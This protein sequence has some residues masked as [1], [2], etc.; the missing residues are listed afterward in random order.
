MPRLLRMPEVAANAVEAVLQEWKVEENT[1]FSAADV[2]ATV[3]TEKAVVDVEAD[4]EGVL[5]KTLVP[6]GAQVEIGAPIALI[7]DAAE[8]VDDL[9]TVMERLGVTANGAVVTPQR[10]EVPDLSG[11]EDG[12]PQ[13]VE[14]PA[15]VQPE[16]SVSAASD[17]EVPAG[18]IFV[19]PLARRIAQERGLALGAIAGTG[20]RGR[21]LRRDVEA[22]SAASAA[23][24]ARA[25]APTAPAGAR[26][27][28]PLMA[29]TDVPH[30]RMRRAIA[31]RL[32]YSKQTVPHFYLRA[33]VQVDELLAVRA[34]LNEAG[35][36]RVSLTDLLVKAVARAHV[37]VPAMN[38]IWTDDAVRSFSSVDISLAVAT[39]RGL[40]T[41]V[42]RGVERM[43]VSVVA[44]TAR[45]LVVR[46]KSG[47]LRQEELEGGT[48]SVTNL[49][50]FGTEE[51]AAII[52]PPQAAILAVGA[53]RQE[54]VVR[55]GQLAVG[56]VMHL[57]LS[58]DHRP[59]D[60]V[61]AAEWMQ[62]LVALLE[63]P[64]RILA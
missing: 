50:M 61:V 36:F 54:P 2:L 24:T 22:A 31:S 40:V 7:A 16:T 37:L 38:V 39:E 8:Q 32:G 35:E 29:Y 63:H 17:D 47:Q 6:N 56:T 13:P 52:N 49:G 30:S 9:D 15:A 41:P 42:L 51:F 1:P 43:P 57:T 59:V 58:V 48:V 5:L 21:I 20:P 11:A 33:T 34:Q 64:V 26:A 46:A 55:E 27:D 62:A 14:T 45:E 25:A 60:G 44:A 28:R 4:A 53:T 18:R 3:E 10:R 19:S 23:A 12:V